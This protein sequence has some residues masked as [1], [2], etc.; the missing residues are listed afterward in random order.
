[1]KSPYDIFKPDLRD[2][3]IAIG[4]SI[5]FYSVNRTPVSILAGSLGAYLGTTIMRGIKYKLRGYSQSEY[6]E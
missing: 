6:L 3:A 5:A 1:M 2:L 4:L